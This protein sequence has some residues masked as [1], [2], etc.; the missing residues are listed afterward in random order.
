[1]S[2]A[3]GGFDADD[4]RALP[5]MIGMAETCDSGRVSKMSLGKK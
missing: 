1:M 2:G 3:P 5:G 4:L